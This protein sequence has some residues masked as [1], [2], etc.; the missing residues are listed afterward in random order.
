MR[1]IMHWVS[2]MPTSQLLVCWC[3]IL[4]TKGYIAFL[5]PWVVGQQ[6]ASTGCTMLWTLIVSTCEMLEINNWEPNKLRTQL[7]SK[8]NHVSFRVVTS[9][10]V[11]SI[12]SWMGH[13][14]ET[15][16]LTTTY[17]HIVPPTQWLKS[18][19]LKYCIW[20]TN[21]LLWNCTKNLE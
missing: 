2:K 11:K 12:P 16:G 6:L 4:K 1:K 7:W 21:D 19:K 8:E 5:P 14:I 20:C 10:W 3:I 17:F 15:K 9:F 18:L 13:P